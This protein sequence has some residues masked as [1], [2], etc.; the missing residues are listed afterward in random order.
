MSYYGTRFDGKNHITYSFVEADSLDDAK[1]QVTEQ[2]V[3]LPEYR[4]AAADA[5]PPERFAQTVLEM[6]EYGRNTVW[7]VTVNGSHE[8][9]LASMDNQGTKVFLYAQNAW[10]AHVPP[11]SPG[12]RVPV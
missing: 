7:V 9:R 11:D 1:Q 4:M 12:M 6:W 8:Y 10:T 5:Q 3:R 2:V